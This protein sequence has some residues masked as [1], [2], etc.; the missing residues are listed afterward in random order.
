MSITEPIVLT[1]EV[2]VAAPVEKVW[3]HFILP[4]HITHWNNA[5]DD[6]HTP[7]AENDL[8]VGGKFSS[9]MEAKDGSFGFDFWGVYDVVDHHR[10]IEYT[11]GDG[12]KVKIHF[13]EDEG[14]TKITEHFEAETTFS[15]EVQQGGWQAI[16]DN[17]KR[18][19]EQ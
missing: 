15:T 9:R 17:F 3:Q 14:T 8:K 4:E 1:V 10:D 13:I 12:R 18:Y 6:W 19:V 7:H 5:S 11:L 2:V 16:M